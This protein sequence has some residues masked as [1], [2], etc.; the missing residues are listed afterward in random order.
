MGRP[1]TKAGKHRVRSFLLPTSK[2][3][4]IWLQRIHRE[5]EIAVRMGFSPKSNRA[6]ASGAQL[7]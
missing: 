2:Q 4:G 7:M 6:S 3:L 5:S 1:Q